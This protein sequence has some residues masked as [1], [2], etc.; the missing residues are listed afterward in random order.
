M[1]T[2]VFSNQLLT[3]DVEVDYIMKQRI[4]TCEWVRVMFCCTRVPTYSRAHTHTCAR[5]YLTFSFLV[6]VSLS[7]R[8]AT[9]IKKKLREGMKKKTA[10]IFT[11]NS[12]YSIAVFYKFFRS[13]AFW[14]LLYIYIVIGFFFFFFFS[15]SWT[16]VCVFFFFF[17]T[18][19]KMQ[20]KTKKKKKEAK[21]LAFG[22][23]LRVFFVQH[24]CFFFVLLIVQKSITTIKLNDGKNKLFIYVRNKLLSI[25]L[26]FIILSQLDN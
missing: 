21:L 4:R 8:P 17:L 13:L 14:P 10:M 5:T 11:S 9:L 1:D 25:F 15:L 26:F 19:S 18:H 7:F 12:V 20:N 2:S 23:L 24:Y 16:H 22:W 3:F 6:F